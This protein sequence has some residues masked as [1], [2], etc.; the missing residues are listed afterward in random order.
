MQKATMRKTSYSNDYVPDLDNVICMVS[1]IAIVTVAK[2]SYC[3][4]CLLGVQD[5]CC[6]GSDRWLHVSWFSNAHDRVIEN[7][8]VQTCRFHSYSVQRPI[9]SV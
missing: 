8:S 1:N 2:T 3:T 6:V 7:V 4:C 9:C 5:T